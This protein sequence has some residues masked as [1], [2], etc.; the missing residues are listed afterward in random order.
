[1]SNAH[2]ARIVSGKFC[3]P[4]VS[5]F[6]MANGESVPDCVPAASAASS[7]PEPETSDSSANAFDFLP[8]GMIFLDARGE[9]VEM[10]R[11]AHRIL[12]AADG[13]RLE[14]R[15]LSAARRNESAA[16]HA[17]IARCVG[18]SLSGTATMIVTR[19]RADS[20]LE[21]M[22]SAITD[23]N[24][25]LSRLA[26]AIVFLNEPSRVTTP[27]AAFLRETLKLSPCE[28]RILNQLLAGDTIDEA[29]RELGVTPNTARTHLKSI[30]LKTG[31]RRQVDLIRRIASSLA[32]LVRRD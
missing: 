15:R 30:F 5:L 7:S 3:R 14:R 21:V 31:V 11:A 10:N 18:E 23:H 32:S 16:L 1:M 29:A 2:C 20:P 6:M 4:S 9:V 12:D 22:V 24:V 25:A 28:I 17:L 27:D 26:A 8:F 13:L 19:D